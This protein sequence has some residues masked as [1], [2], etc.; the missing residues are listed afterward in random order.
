MGYRFLAQSRFEWLDLLE[1]HCQST[2]ERLQAHSIALCIQD[3]TEL[4]FNGQRTVGRDPLSYEA[5]PEDGLAPPLA[6]SP[7]REPFG[8]SDLW[9]RVRAPKDAEG[10][11][12][13]VKHGT[14]RAEGYARV[15]EPAEHTPMT[16]LVY[17]GYREADLLALM[18]RA[19]DLGYAADDLVRA[20]H[21]RV[22]PEGE[23]LWNEVGAETP[24][25]EIRF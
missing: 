16:R 13:S 19:R 20:T 21:T 8:I 15:A 9:M 18:V 22:L 2:R 7:A 17:V 12:A 25:G 3:T 24:L 14:R 5:R 10:A 23:R 11:R 1:P 6:V 4:V